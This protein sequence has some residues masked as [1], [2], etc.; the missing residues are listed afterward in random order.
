MVD[1]GHTMVN[2]GHSDEAMVDIGYSN[3]TMVDIGLYVS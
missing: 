3:D 1:V 2:I